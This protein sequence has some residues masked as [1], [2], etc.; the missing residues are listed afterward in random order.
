M[1]RRRQYSAAP[2][3]ALALC[4]GCSGDVSSD[5]PPVAGDVPDPNAEVD[6][7]DALLGSNEICS[8]GAPPRRVILISDS[9]YVTSVQTLLPGIQLP[10]TAAVTRQQASA[11]AQVTPPKATQFRLW[12][13]AAAE[14]TVANLAALTPCASATPDAACALTFVTNLAEQAYRRPLSEVDIARLEA[15][16]AQGNL[17]GPAAGVQLAVSAILQSPSFLYR[18]E[19]GQPAANAAAVALAPHEIAANLAATFLGN[20]P[21]A[22]LR[23][24]A[25]SGALSTPEQIGEQIERL[26]QSAEAQ[27]GFAEQVEHWFSIP[28]VLGVAV[29]TESYPEATSELQASLYEESSRFIFDQIWNQGASYGQLLTSRSSFVN[30]DLAGLY[31]LSVNPGA[32]FAAV[33]LPPERAGLL[34]RGA[35]LT[36]FFGNANSA[37]VHRGVF[38]R[39]HVLCA[40]V[41]APPPDIQQQLNMKAL[42]DY[43]RAARMSQAPCN[44]CHQVIETVG[45]AFDRFNGIGRFDPSIAQP[46]STLSG[47]DVDGPINDALELSQR[48]AQSQQVSA[49]AVRHALGFVQALAVHEVDACL[50]ERVHAIYQE[51]GGRLDALLASA[52]SEPSVFLR[53]FGESQ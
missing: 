44:G 29:D 32:E 49:C 31:G 18:T 43:D 35:F 13:D 50:L 7:G 6:P 16:L 25:A 21:D 47:T 53:T 2:L 42:D 20:V 12:A 30:G 10:D 8:Q 37:S 33:E 24:A 1:R 19:L 27:Y 51:N 39:E 22:G 48:L 36:G 46:A 38:V 34:T 45:M 26:I 41:P 4:V 17:D 9:E 52:L 28:K 23:Q 40:P 15:L 3:W 5:A 14:A 11:F